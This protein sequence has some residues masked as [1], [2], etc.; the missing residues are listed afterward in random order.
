MG[1]I[2]SNVK[3]AST[4]NQYQHWHKFLSDHRNVSTIF[5]NRAEH[6]QF[7][8]S[9]ELI[10]NRRKSYLYC[11]LF[12]G[13][14]YRCSITFPDCYGCISGTIIYSKQWI[15]FEI[16]CFNQHSDIQTVAWFSNFD[17][18]QRHE[19]T[20]QNSIRPFW[21]VAIWKK[22]IFFLKYSTVRL[23]ALLIR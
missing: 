16:D 22:T 12:F 11:I 15:S 19:N 4:I 6:G 2:W 1:N 23:S 5:Q 9:P 14:V 20:W 10:E 18:T 8:S 21:I 13:S 3:R 17:D 7:C